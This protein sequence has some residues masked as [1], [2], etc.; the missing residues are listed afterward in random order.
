[1]TDPVRAPDR[2]R[3][4]RQVLHRR[5]VARAG[6]ARDRRSRGQSGNRRGHGQDSARKRRGCGRA[7]SRPAAGIRRL[8]PHAPAERRAALTRSSMQALLERA[9]ADRAG[10]DPR[11][12]GGDRLCAKRAGPA[13]SRAHVASRARI[14]AGFPFVSQRGT[15]R[16]PREPIGVC[17]LITPW[18]WPLYQITAKV[19]PALAAGCTVVLKPS[20]LSPLNALL[21]AEI[22][23]R[24]A[25][26]RASS[27]SSTGRAGGR[28]GA[29]YTSGGRHGLDHRLD[30]GG[31]AVAQAA[32]RPSSALR[33]SSAASRPMSC[34]RTPISPAACR[35]ASPPPC[36]ISASPA[37]RLRACWSRAGDWPRSRRW[38]RR[39][40]VNSWW[41]IPRGRRPLTER[42]PIAPST[43]ESR[44]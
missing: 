27:T 41:A 30:A 21:F 29:R 4:S 5:R 33:R 36:A 8:V 16:D 38:P 18:N 1:M 44:R 37:A 12:G 22:M 7:V 28:R 24:R 2:G 34:C 6:G 43:T 39:Q 13:R 19:G 20:E 15:H 31:R 10:A 23:E 40:Q 42:S 9:R 14:L 26:R 17:A 25:A 35:W 3:P 32:A 11:D